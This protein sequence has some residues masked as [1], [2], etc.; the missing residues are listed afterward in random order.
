M[1]DVLRQQA[2]FVSSTCDMHIGTVSPAASPASS[3]RARWRSPSFCMQAVT[4]N[5]AG[6]G[7]YIERDRQRPIPRTPARSLV[8]VS[9]PSTHRDVRDS[10]TRPDDASLPQSPPQPSLTDRAFSTNNRERALRTPVCGWG[11]VRVSSGWVLL[12][13]VCCPIMRDGKLASP[14]WADGVSFHL[15]CQLARV[16]SRASPSLFER[17]TCR[18]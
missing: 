10:C 17:V 16:F 14:A 2:H 7:T 3:C 4:T 13:S 8:L 11:S 6:T 18:L 15:G 9:D 12:R 1:I 5:G